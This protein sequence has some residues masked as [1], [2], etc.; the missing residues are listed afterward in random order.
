MV[1]ILCSTPYVKPPPTYESR[2]WKHAEEKRQHK[3][4]DVTRET[5]I[6]HAH[7]VTEGCEQNII[8][9]FSFFHK[10]GNMSWKRRSSH[11][12]NEIQMPINSRQKAHFNR[13]EV[14][15]RDW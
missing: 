8:I 13:D 1:D 15:E 4:R 9:F 12:L 10:A 7:W 6:L 3:K 14:Q 5:D 11:G 2:L